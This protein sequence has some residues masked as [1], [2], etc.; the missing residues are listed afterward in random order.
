MN[1]ANL[2]LEGLLLALAA[3]LEKLEERNLLSRDDIRDALETARGRCVA[4]ERR[5]VELSD[6]NV[7]AVMFPIRFLIRAVEPDNAGG[8]FSELARDIGRR[9]QP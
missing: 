5:P 2:Q 7:E 8:T 4:D 9:R 3:I 1:T 6:A